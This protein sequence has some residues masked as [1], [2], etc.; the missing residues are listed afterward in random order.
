MAE[1]TPKT[2]EQILRDA[3]DYLYSNTNLSDFNV[4]SVIRTILEVM[5][6]EDA[7]QYFQMFSILESFFLD[8][9][10]GGALDDRAAQYDVARIPASGSTGE[11]IFLDTQLKR[12]FLVSDVSPGDPTLFV[13][14]ASTFP[15]TPF[16]VQ[17]GESGN[18]EQVQISAVSL[19]VNSLTVDVAATPPLNAVTYDHTSAASGVDEVDN[20]SS[21]VCHV[22]NAEAP[23]IIA[24]GVTLRA[25]PTNIS[26][27]V[28]CIT[29]EVGT[30]QVGYFTSGAIRVKSTTVGDQSSVPSKRLN[31][32]VGGSPYSGASV[33][34]KTAVSGGSTA[35]LDQSLRQRIRDSI[36]ALPSGTPTAIASALLQVSD[37]V[38]NQVITR[39]RIVEDFDKKT[40]WAYVDD[41]SSTFTID[42][43][44]NASDTLSALSTPIL[45][46]LNNLD[47]FETATI[48]NPKHIIIDPNGVAPFATAYDVLNPT[49]PP[50]LST[51]DPVAPVFPIATLVSQ[52]EVVTLSSEDGRKYYFLDKFPLGDDALR[53]Y[54]APGA[55]GTATLLTELLPGNI[56]TYDVATGVLVE[57]YLLNKATGQIE[58]FEEKIPATGS[59]VLALYE[60]YINLLKSAQ[61]VVDGDLLDRASFP[62]V[63]SAGVKVLVRAAKRVPVNVT[64]DITLDSDQTDIDTAGFLARQLIV[65][66]VNNLDI[67]SDV[68]IAEI[69][70]RVMSVLGVTNC[71]V[72]E[73]NDDK[74]INYDEV[75]Y[76]LNTVIT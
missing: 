76:A 10:S 33:I 7:E 25:E 3:I 35:E 49:I 14:D 11:V 24:S 58:F 13:A 28:E 36:A 70:D 66:Y 34:N 73:P 12:S 75:A 2:S 6:M 41:A 53:L 22:N 47:D 39:S 55:L 63:R 40:V 15:A 69:I 59:S 23:R 60:N 29:T 50:Q 19:T 51:L 18:V 43:V 37:P 16:T 1:F 5:S 17:L 54:R 27:S 4:G 74:T 61:T 56:K 62:G 72:I 68:I 67:G 31:Q 38:T 64:V 20:L 52:C 26:F 71:K 21:L 30:Q 46:T 57:D 8:N 44:R 45:L 32:I 65:T 48:S 42:E 9:A